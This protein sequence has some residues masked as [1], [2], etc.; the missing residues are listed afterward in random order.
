MT[1]KSQSD[2]AFSRRDTLRLIGLGGTAALVGLAGKTPMRHFPDPERT[3]TESPDLPGC[4]VRPAQTE[5]PYFIDERLNRADIRTDPSNNSVRE[6]LPLRLKINVSKVDD[7]GSC[8]PLPGAFVDIWQCDAMGVYSDFKDFQGRFDTRG[9]KFLRGYQ[10]TDDKGSVELMTIYPG[11][12]PGRAVHVHF[13][14]RLFIGSEHAH[15][16][17]SQLY[18]DDSFTDQVYTRPPYNTKETRKM[19][20]NGDF[21]FRDK[22][23][24]E[25]LVLD[26]ARDGQGCSGSF[27]IGLAGM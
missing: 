2:H 12:Y 14:I 9:Q 1:T 11:W 13:K 7:R 25:K 16:F 21:I 4:V 10:V 27:D 3:S 17:T 23:S 15:E 26:V 18:F 6:G 24:G 5:G 8:G 22:N 19:R 20:N